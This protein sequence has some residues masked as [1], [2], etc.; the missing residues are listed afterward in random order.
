VN[1]VSLDLEI[2]KWC[3]KSVCILDI[4]TRKGN[5]ED[6]ICLIVFVSVA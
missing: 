4:H 2:P 5:V 1:L 6:G 3:A